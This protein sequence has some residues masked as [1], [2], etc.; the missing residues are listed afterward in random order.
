MYPKY[1]DSDV[2]AVS[3]SVSSIQANFITK[4]YGWMCFALVM[5]AGVSLAVASTPALI[6]MIMGNQIL[7]FG[8]IIGEL[9][10]VWILVGAIN[11]MSA[12]TAT[13][14]FIAY[15]A[16][17][18]LTLSVI[19]LAYTASSITSTFFITAGTFGAMS[20][21]GYVTKRDLTSVGNLCFMC[22][23]GAIIAM[24]VNIFLQSSILYWVISFAGVAIFV[25]LTAYDTQRIKE[26]ATSVE[27]NFES[28][29]KG[30]VLGALALYLDFINLF[31]FLLR[32]F[33]G[34]R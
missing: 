23:I 1:T 15:S 10:M 14:M 11:K 3:Q 25:G 16:L 34:R 8:L 26:M 20:L 27:G 9:A 4:V 29:R 32:I 2:G 18:G 19:F 33:G 12:H 5:T 30:A 6:K 21:Y 13:A 28:G 7:F 22:L 17:N 24:V 31:I